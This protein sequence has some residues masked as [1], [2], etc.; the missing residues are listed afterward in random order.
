MVAFSRELDDLQWYACRKPGISTA[1]RNMDAK[2]VKAG[3]GAAGST[4][5]VA[6]SQIVIGGQGMV[7]AGLWSFDGEILTAANKHITHDGTSTADYIRLRPGHPGASRSMTIQ[8][9][10]TIPDGY[11]Y[12]YATPANNFSQVSRFPGTRILFELQPHNGSTLT[13]LRL[14]FKTTYSHT[15]LPN[16]PKFRVVRVDRSGNVQALHTAR[17]G[18]YKDDGYRDLPSN[19]TSV[20]NYEAAGAFQWGNAFVPD[21]YNVIDVASYA[22]FVDFVE[23]SGANAFVPDVTLNPGRGTVILRGEMTCASI[24]HMGP[25]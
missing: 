13:S 1:L 12:S 21:Q 11:Q 15:N 17:S 9:L 19:F 2:T 23:E 7:C 4:H 16:A 25:Q 10:P 20:A 18:N 14:M 22:Y 24:S 3:N 5:M 6:G 8:V